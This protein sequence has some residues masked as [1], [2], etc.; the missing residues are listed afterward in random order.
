MLKWSCLGLV[1]ALL[2]QVSPAEAQ[3]P[4][5]GSASPKAAEKSDKTPGA[6]ESD[7]EVILLAGL[8]VGKGN[9]EIVSYA[10]RTYLFTDLILDA[11]L[12][13]MTRMALTKIEENPKNCESIK[14]EHLG[15][16]SHHF[17][18]QAME[19]QARNMGLADV[20][21]LAQIAVRCQ[22]SN[23]KAKLFYSN[24]LHSNLGR[25][26]DAIQTLQHGLEFLSIDDP[27]ARDYI[28]RYFQFLQ[29][30]ERDAEV[31]SQGLKLLQSG[32]TLTPPVREAAA[33]GVATSLYWT[34]QYPEAVATIDGASLDRQAG[35]LLLKAR[36]LFD[37][38]RTREAVTLL[39]GR[40][41]D[42]KG[43]AKDA[44]LAQLGRFHLLLGQPK[45]ALTIADERISAE[46]K[47]PFPRLQ[48]LHALDRIG[49][50]EEYEKELR[51]V[52]ER[53]ADSAPAM[54]A[55]ANFAAERGYDGLTL[56][57]ANQSAA[58]GFEKATFAALH[59]EALI[60]AKGYDEVITQHRQVTAADRAFFKTNEPLVQA[61][62]GIAHH[63]RPKKDDL[64][65]KRDRDV[66]DR[67]LQEFLK[68]PNLGPEAYRSV[69]RH[70]RT[71]RAAETAVRVLEAG[72]RAHPRYSQLRADLIGARILAGLTE[73]YGDRRAL[74]DDVDELLK[75]RRPSPLV[76]QEVLGW[77]RTEAKLPDERRRRLEKEIGP[78]TRPNLD[79]EAL[80][81]R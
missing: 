36:S 62:L 29:L 28:E 18:K 23:S 81:G 9:A 65:A 72:V 26:D 80:A 31:I 27:L 10:R 49:L 59:L 41:S 40:T 46:P 42:F 61:L 57:V 6:E 38:G 77:I 3:A 75:M 32:K 52:L 44:I 76:W 19:G 24:I 25:T 30:R 64:S 1:L 63:G 22:P 53:F 11:G 68:A 39:E 35:G 55:L 8:P 67:Y 14:A 12:Q 21:N 70:L 58:R 56:T 60:N 15:L 20:L 54:I 66:G 2:G 16:V 17:L 74:A 33:T 50:R 78:L 43:A 37:G 4:E 13:Q 73:G 47:A 71:V 45:V 48:R 34:G 69:G 5:K 79:Q 7:A 51:T